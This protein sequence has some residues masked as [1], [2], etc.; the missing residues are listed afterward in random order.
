MI[1]EKKIKLWRRTLFL[2]LRIGLFFVC[3]EILLR[4]GGWGFIT[5]QDFN[6][7][8][9][10]TNSVRPLVILC[11]GESTTAI[12]GRDSYPAQLE[13]YL[14]QINS[15]RTYKVINKGMPG[16]NTQDILIRLKSNLDT[17]HPDLVITMIGIN[18][19]ELKA[20]SKAQDLI[21]IPFIKSL[22]T[23]QL[24]NHITSS[25]TQQ[26]WL[27]SHAKRNKEI[28]RIEDNTEYLYL[29]D[30]SQW[31]NTEKIENL[32]KMIDDAAP[33]IE[34]IKLEMIHYLQNVQINNVGEIIAFTNYSDRLKELD[35]YCLW[36]GDWY[37]LQE[38]YH[39]AEIY[40]MKAIDLYLPFDNVKGYLKL[41][42][43]YQRQAQWLNSILLMKKIFKLYP[44][45]GEILFELGKSYAGIGDKESAIRAFSDLLTIF[46]VDQPRIYT[47]VGEWF[48]AQG[49]FKV[50]KV[51]YLKAIQ[52]NP[53]KYL[54]VYEKL[55]EIYI[56]QGR[57]EDAQRVLN[58]GISQNPSYG[59]LYTQLYHL[60]RQKGMSY[61][62]QVY[63]DKSQNFL[64]EQYSLGTV[65]TYQAIAK[66]VLERDI[67]LIVMQYPL[68]SIKPL[69]EFLTGQ[70]GITF[71]ENIGNFEKALTSKNYNDLFSDNFGL[72]FGHCTKKGNELIA[73]QLAEVIVKLM[74][75]IQP[76]QD[77]YRQ[78]F[79]F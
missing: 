35:S 61:L 17:Y 59:R 10:I 46:N 6:N 58:Q 74:K 56:T 26:I 40:Y 12:G 79:K 52:L 27:R 78:H 45:N 63:L 24:I 16:L 39:E 72:D 30:F 22:R 29:T 2:L 5:W 19:Q 66:I 68:R 73:K 13:R 18:D 23:Y 57:W 1:N 41:S 51:A 77:R 33:E 76:I 4:L 31:M 71:V 7:R 14:N 44:D 49:D 62:A 25:L 70:E 55:G 32:K 20:I 50:A 28:Q 11:L 37:V 34:S 36:V 60:Y 65:E 47:E 64:K 69:Q 9:F 42:R 54:R 48:Q 21:P 75:P 15:P 53:D 38:E 8:I 43:C 3:F 67:K